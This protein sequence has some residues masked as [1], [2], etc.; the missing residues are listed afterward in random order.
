MN[1]RERGSHARGVYPIQYTSSMRTVRV[2]LKEER[3][4]NNSKRVGRNLDKRNLGMK[5][6]SPK[7]GLTN[8][9]DLTNDL[10]EGVCDNVSRNMVRSGNNNTFRTAN[11]P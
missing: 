8:A 6:R 2:E 3:H 7:Q 9:K 5:G 4:N 11:G 10:S 1:Y